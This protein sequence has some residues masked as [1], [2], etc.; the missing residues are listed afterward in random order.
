MEAMTGVAL[1]WV[2]GGTEGCLDAAFDPCLLALLGDRLDVFLGAPGLTTVGTT[3][4][5]VLPSKF[6]LG[7]MNI[8]KK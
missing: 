2:E 8:F 4:V 7:L 1:R 3:P 5:A 6:S